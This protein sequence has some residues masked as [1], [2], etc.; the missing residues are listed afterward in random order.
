MALLL[1]LFVMIAQMQFPIHQTV[2]DAVWNLPTAFSLVYEGNI[3]L[4]EYQ[5]LINQFPGLGYTLHYVNNTPYNIYPVGASMFAMPFVMAAGWISNT[6]QSVDLHTLSQQMI[7]INLDMFIACVTVAATA[8]F[9]YLIARF[10]LTSAPALLIAVIFAFGTTALSVASRGLWQHGPSMLMLTITLYALLRAQRSPAFLTLAGFT[11]AFAYIIRPTNSISVV[12]LTL[13]VL[14]R[15]RLQIIRFIVGALLISL[16]FFYLNLTVYG[17]VFAPYFVSYFLPSLS[18]SGWLEALLGNLVSPSRGLFIF[19]SVLLFS[20]GGIGFKVRKRSMKGL[21]YALA[22]ILILHWML[23][24]LYLNWW[25]GFSFGPRYMTDVLPY[26]AFFLIPLFVY[27]PSLSRL[28]FWLVT[29]LL[30]ITIFASVAIYFRGSTEQATQ[31]WNSI[32]VSVDEAPGRVWDW[33]D[34]QFLRGI[35]EPS[36]SIELAA[37]SAHRFEFDA[38]SLAYEGSGWG[39]TEHFK[40]GTTFQWMVEKQAALMIRLTTRTDLQV[41]IGILRAVSPELLANFTF[42]VNGVPIGL[43]VDNGVYSGY[44]PAITL[45]ANGKPTILQFT[46]DHVISPQSLGENQ[47]T[48]TLGLMLDYLD[49]QPIQ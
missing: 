46:V 49:I 14:L 29:A 4:T 23:M 37:V 35:G 45:S 10:Y 12:V 9:L 7:L 25:A 19:S 18:V 11:L 36:A 48:R 38:D 1:F 39:D 44:I 24:S 21:D 41:E 3:D 34:V 40:D 5:T 22:M 26:F 47:D 8:A 31:T 42:S 17:Q 20:L 27:L 2:G 30:A 16:P 13:Y 6:F 15:Y 28:R 33:T 32:P 43:R